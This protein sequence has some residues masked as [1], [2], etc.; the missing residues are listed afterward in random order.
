MRHVAIL[1]DYL[2]ALDSLC[3]AH[4]IVQIYGPIL[5]NPMRALAM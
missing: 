4:N 5:F 1:G 2:Q 3:I